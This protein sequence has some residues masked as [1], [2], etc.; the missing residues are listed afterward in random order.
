MRLDGVAATQAR[1]GS[2]HSAAGYA[3]STLTHRRRA[4]D[5][6]YVMALEPRGMQSSH[7]HKGSIDPDEDDGMN[8]ERPIDP[9]RSQI[10][11]P[12][13]LTLRQAASRAAVSEGTLKREVRRR[14]IRSARVGGR[15]CLRFRPSWIDAWLEA[16]STPVETSRG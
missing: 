9:D 13:W 14:R 7:P 6:N 16:S 1:Q 12:A 3:D 4:P 8:Q 2:A 5:G 11:D 15:R 10:C